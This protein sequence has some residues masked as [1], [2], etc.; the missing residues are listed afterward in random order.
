[1]QLSVDPSCCSRSKRMSGCW[2]QCRNSRRAASEPMN[3]HHARHVTWLTDARFPHT[4]YPQTLGHPPPAPHNC[5]TLCLSCTLIP[6]I[7]PLW[8]TTTCP[9]RSQ[10][11]LGE[12]K[13]C[14]IQHSGRKTYVKDE[15]IWERHTWAGLQ[16]V[17]YY[18]CGTHLPGNFLILSCSVIL[19]DYFQFVRCLFPFSGIKKIAIFL[20]LIILSLLGV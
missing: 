5:M 17:K 2:C 13:G 16:A 3:A 20:P 1:M 18:R 14:V 6:M 9:L 4:S 12:V 8:Q 15:G 10:N 7:L 19:M 11:P